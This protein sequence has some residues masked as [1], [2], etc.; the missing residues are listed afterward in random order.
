MTFYA[1]M[2]ARMKCSGEVRQVPMVSK[3]TEPLSVLQWG[4]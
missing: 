3:P 4:M 2:F 1:N